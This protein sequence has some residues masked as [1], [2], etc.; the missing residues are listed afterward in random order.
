LG[1]VLFVTNEAQCG[2]AL[3]ID[4]SYDVAGKCLALSGF[5]VFV[6]SP[7]SETQ[8]HSIAVIAA[9][10]R[11]WFCVDDNAVWGFTDTDVLRIFA[12]Q[13]GRARPLILCFTR[14][15]EDVVCTTTQCDLPPIADWIEDPYAF[16]EPLPSRPLPPLGVVDVPKA[17]GL[18]SESGEVRVK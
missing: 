13:F 11:G 8:G 15:R 9:R 16:H 10:G 2:V 4:R 3:E 6:R 7:H 12:G 17:T 14:V 5:V 1:D 18:S